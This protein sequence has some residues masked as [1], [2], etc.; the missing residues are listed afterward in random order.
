[1]HRVKAQMTTRLMLKI[2]VTVT[3]VIG[4][5]GDADAHLVSGCTVEGTI[6]RRLES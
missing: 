3:A 2:L 1:M 6:A 5:V 4:L